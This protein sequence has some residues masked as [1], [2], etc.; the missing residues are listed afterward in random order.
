MN[1]CS[2][3]GAGY[4]SSPQAKWG[5]C[6]ACKDIDVA[7]M[8][9]PT[10]KLTDRS[11]LPQNQLK[12]VLAWNPE[13]HRGLILL[14]PS[15][16]CKTRC[17][18]ELVKEAHLSNAKVFDGVSF[19][20]ELARKYQQGGAEDWLD[21][22]GMEAPRVM[23]DDLGKLKLTDRVES[24][25]FGIVDR[26]YSYMLPMIITTQL[27]GVGLGG[28]MTDGRGQA[29]VRRLREACDIVEF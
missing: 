6:N 20:L 27:D 5:V 22:L 29:M 16:T 19:G 15:G 14:G 9:P 12:K 1:A 7:K 28:V 11:R 25:L 26:R 3:C 13:G 17:M 21:H 10:F 18:W 2:K 8:V 23:F 4:G 24:E